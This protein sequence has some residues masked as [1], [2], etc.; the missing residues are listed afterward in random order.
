MSTP[1]TRYF[2]VEPDRVFIPPKGLL[3]GPGATSLTFRAGEVVEIP[4]TKIDRFVRNRATAGDIREV[5]A[6]DATAIRTATA[7]AAAVSAGP[8]VTPAKEG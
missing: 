7:R 4:A 8:N 1:Q 5:K 2:V 3:A 6:S